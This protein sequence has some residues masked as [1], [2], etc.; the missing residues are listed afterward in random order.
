MEYNDITYSMYT[1]LIKWGCTPSKESN[2]VLVWCDSSPYHTL[3]FFWS[4]DLRETCADA[5][6]RIS[7]LRPD[8]AFFFQSCAPLKT[9]VAGFETDSCF[10]HVLFIPAWDEDFMWRSRDGLKPEDGWRLIFINNTRLVPV[11]ADFQAHPFQADPL[12][13]GGASLWSVL[14]WNPVEWLRSPYYPKMMLIIQYLYWCFCFLGS[15]YI[16]GNARH[17]FKELIGVKA[18]TF[19][20]LALRHAC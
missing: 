1:L 3:D 10:F 15:Q 8:F 9:A 16:R 18:Q 6:G 12:T 20:K 5:A 17:F 4:Q 19:I 7:R 2:I 14:Q 13:F 11:E